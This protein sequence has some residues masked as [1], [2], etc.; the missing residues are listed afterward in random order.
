MDSA[1]LE[2]SAVFSLRR[3]DGDDNLHRA[4]LFFDAAVGL[5]ADPVQLANRV[6]HGVDEDPVVAQDVADVRLGRLG[7]EQAADARLELLD[8]QA[9]RDGFL[10]EL[11]LRFLIGEAQQRAGVALAQ[12]GF[13]QRGADAIGKAQQPQPVGQCGRAQRKR[14]GERLLRDAV[15]VENR[16]IG[17][18]FVEVV[19]VFALKVFCSR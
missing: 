3:V 2:G 1:G 14:P 11:E 5:H 4:G 19:E 8:G 12:P 7:R 13:A 18:G 17:L 10:N 15:R 9:V 6:E 16:A